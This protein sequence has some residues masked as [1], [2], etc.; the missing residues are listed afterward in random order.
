MPRKK[1]SAPKGNVIWRQSS[2]EVALASKP[3]H[4]GY[5]CGHGVHGDVKYSRRKQK[6]EL[7]ALLREDW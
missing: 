3:R 4:N 1:H 7:H 2:L 5:A 6:R